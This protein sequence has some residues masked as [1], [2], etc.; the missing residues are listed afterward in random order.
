[1]SKAKTTTTKKQGPK[2]A[3]RAKATKRAKTT[4]IFLND[5][6]L[7]EILEE[8]L[9]EN[10]KKHKAVD[11]KAAQKAFEAFGAE[12]NFDFADPVAF[13]RYLLMVYGKNSTLE[14]QD[15]VRNGHDAPMLEDKSL[16]YVEGYR[17][18]LRSYLKTFAPT[19]EMVL[20]RGLN[21]VAWKEGEDIRASMAAYRIR[22]WNEES[23]GKPSTDNYS[24][25]MVVG[26]YD[27]STH[28]M[29]RRDYV[30]VTAALARRIVE[31]DPT[32]LYE[33]IAERRVSTDPDM[34]VKAR[35]SPGKVRKIVNGKV[36]MVNIPRKARPERRVLL[37]N[38][39]KKIIALANKLVT[40]TVIIVKAK[41]KDIEAFGGDSES[42]DTQEAEL[43]VKACEPGCVEHIFVA[44]RVKLGRVVSAKLRRL[45]ALDE[46]LEVEGKWFY[47]SG[48]P[49]KIKLEL[50]PATPI[51]KMKAKLVKHLP[52]GFDWYEVLSLMTEAFERK[53][54]IMSGGG[55]L[56]ATSEAWAFRPW[57]TSLA[58]GRSVT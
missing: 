10:S 32:I 57:K 16:D 1:M 26:A 11:Y 29:G 46:H 47:G 53:Q 27:F 13:S 35:K 42:G 19:G 34:E 56:P 12:N 37:P 14:I 30:Y 43:K 21:R 23:K 39:K 38:E 4:K 40:P 33:D 52:K 58:E 18:M 17:K 5:D 49:N 6:L 28:R 44:S 45:Y 36:K 31:E 2:A 7:A 48:E 51:G 55:P 20:S 8:D 15:M 54:K 22:R 50:H 24:Q 9:G 3:K 25:N 41:H